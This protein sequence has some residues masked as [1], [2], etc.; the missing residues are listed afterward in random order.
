M[1]RIGK[2]QLAGFVKAGRVDLQRHP[3]VKSI[4][5]K[6]LEK[7]TNFIDSSS[8]SFEYEWLKTK[9]R[10]SSSDRYKPRPVVEKYFSYCNSIKREYKKSKGLYYVQPILL[11]WT[12]FIRGRMNRDIS[13]LIKGIEDALNGLAYPDDNLKY[14]KGYNHVRVNILGSEFITESF[15]IQINPITKLITGGNN[16]NFK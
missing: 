7:P 11:A 4:N 13:N 16:G 1:V 8:I 5:K 2:R 15:C 10:M 3:K 9:P 12:F 6:T 14:I